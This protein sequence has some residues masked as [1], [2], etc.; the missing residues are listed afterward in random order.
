M[1]RLK[2]SESGDSYGVVSTQEA[3]AF[4]FS[5]VRNNSIRVPEIT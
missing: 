1:A 4:F 2:Q 3:L 5:H